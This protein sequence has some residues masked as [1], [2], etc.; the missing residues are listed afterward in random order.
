MTQHDEYISHDQGFIRRQIQNEPHQRW[1]DT[2][3]VLVARGQ[4]DAS[5]EAAVRDAIAR[6]D[7]KAMLRLIRTVTTTRELRS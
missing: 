7:K 2:L 6:R 4:F 3:S 5:G 1:I